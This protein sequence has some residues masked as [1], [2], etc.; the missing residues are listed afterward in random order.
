MRILLL[1]LALAG[2]VV[3]FELPAPS[4]QCVVGIADGW[5]D[6]HVTLTAYEKRGGQWQ[7]VMGPWPGR[8]GKNGLVWGAGI[9]PAEGQRT[10]R[11]GD[12]RAP[13]GVFRIGG[14]WG[15]DATIQKD[16]KLFYRRITSRDLWVEDSKSPSYNRHV[17]L[18][19]EPATAWERKQQMR[20]N[21]HAHSLK[22]FIGHNS[23]PQ[24]VPGA[25]SAIFFHIWRGGGS[26]PTAG[27]TTM[28]EEKLRQ[29]IAWIDPDQQPLYVL[30]PKAEYA[31]L[32]AEW[33]LP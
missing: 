23:P 29:L 30:L 7:K 17:V 9:S 5:N 32:R 4:R 2:H 15:Y 20:Q 12:G 26:K 19:H 28:P 31:R 21:D 16:P 25:G 18:D 22:L 27:C 33:K 14:A 10:K 13:A 11:E 1:I 24:V 8:L 3:A 6:S